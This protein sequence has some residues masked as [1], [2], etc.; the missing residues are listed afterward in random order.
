L[1][2]AFSAGVAFAQSTTAVGGPF[3]RDENV[4]V[5]D[6]ARPDYDAIG[7]PLG[8]FLI[9]PKLEASEAYDDNVF[10]TQSAAK[11]DWITS[12]APS[13]TAQS[14]WSNNSLSAGVHSDTFEYGR[15]NTESNTTYGANLNGRI[16]VERGTQVS[17]GVAYDRVI[18]PRSDAA[19]PVNS[20]NPVQ[21]DQTGVD[22]GASREVDRI[23]LSGAVAYRDYAFSNVS[24]STG[25]VINQTYRS[26]QT[27]EE[28][29][30]GD[31]AVSPDFAV[32]ATVI[33]DSANY[34]RQSSPDKIDRN[35]SSVQ[36]DVGTDFQLSRLLRAQVQV[37][38]LQPHYDQPGLSSSGGVA[39]LGKV[40][41]FPTQLLT[42]TFN[43]S[44]SIQ[45]SGVIGSAATTNTTGGV[46]AD[47]ELL[48][49]LILTAHA[50]R[51]EYDYDGISRTDEDW[52]A[53]A[54]ATYLITRWVGLNLTYTYYDQ[55][56][57]GVGRGPNFADNRVQAGIVLQY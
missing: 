43:G 41:Y 19:A 27:W 56:S 15:Y 34:N 24:T 26:N 52:S 28:S 10:A 36:F 40:E 17:A 1:S 14:Q 7:M 50:Q 6:R 22:F 53:L 33:N 4:S 57:S 42:L 35:T 46:Q 44:R 31:Y 9:F 16:D 5:R 38:Y 3:A 29:L 30:R 13:L 32:F 25:A 12:L 54:G 48:R 49:N 45:S 20:K 39:L 18:D 47:Y 55:A 8:A 21:Y 37:G 23:K 11:S 51:V 2:V